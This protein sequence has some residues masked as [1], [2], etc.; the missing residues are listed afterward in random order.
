MA[1]LKSLLKPE[2]VLNTDFKNMSLEELRD[3]L[4]E[5][6]LGEKDSLDQNA[7][8]YKGLKSFHSRFKEK[9]IEAA[10]QY[11]SLGGKLSPLMFKN[12]LPSSDN[13]VGLQE[14]ICL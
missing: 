11:R 9:R 4:R 8:L 5:L 3:H 12:D 7:Y 1:Y 14:L 10:K 2:Q 6:V 13:W